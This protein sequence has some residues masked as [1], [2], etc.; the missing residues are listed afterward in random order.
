VTK[1]IVQQVTF[2][3]KPERLYHLYMDSRLHTASTGSGAKMSAK[4]GGAFSAWD[5]YIT[6]KNLALRPRRAIVQSWRAADWG[7]SDEDS[8]FFLAFDKAPGGAVVTMVHANV[9]D[10]HAR[11]ITKGWFTY[12]WQPW[13]T[14]LRKQ[15]A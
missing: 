7:D 11:G 9:P 10:A 2:K 5:G 3:A 6:G 4:V 1:T 14:Y 12:Y 13:K 8:I 15:R